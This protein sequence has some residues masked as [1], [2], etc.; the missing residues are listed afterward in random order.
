LVISE[1]P[2]TQQKTLG[3]WERD[4][5]ELFVAPKVEHPNKYFE[6]EA[7]PTGEWVDLGINVTAGGRKTDW[8]YSSGM[9]VRT[10]SLDN[11][12]KILMTIPW[13]ES[14]P[15]PEVGMQWRVNL[16][17]CVGPEAPSRYLAWQPTGTPEPNF[18]VPDKF[19][20]LLFK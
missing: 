11:S 20:W 13:T 16:F 9:S 6:F 15:K 12:V 7:A 8:E 2:L 3:L 4:V 5:C 10:Q 17:R 14:I 18:H 1:K 19:G